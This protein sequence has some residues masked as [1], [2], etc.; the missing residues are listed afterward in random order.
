MKDQ[1]ASARGIA[2][3]P[4]PLAGNSPSRS[5][6]AG[7]AEPPIAR[8]PWR[9][10]EGAARKGRISLCEVKDLDGN[11]LFHATR[12]IAARVV[13]AVNAYTFLFG[14]S[15]ELV[16]VLKALQAQLCAIPS[17]PARAL[18]LIERTL[19]PERGDG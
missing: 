13:T 6:G 8:T 18:D 12:P 15:I 7:K 11:V 17:N 19:N 16:D 10:V 5:S 14:R 2:E 1:S 3:G 9:V 4:A